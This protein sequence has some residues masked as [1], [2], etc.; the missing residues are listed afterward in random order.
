M[1]VTAADGR[2]LEVEV[3]GPAGGPAVVFHT[4]TP[5]GGSLLGELL[6]E[7]IR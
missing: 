3:A 6:D 1:T 4:G 2:L 5:S 7:L